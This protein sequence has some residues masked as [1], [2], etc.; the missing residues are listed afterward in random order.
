MANLSDGRPDQVSTFFI[1]I[2]LVLGIIMMPCEY[3]A[4]KLDIL[5]DG[6]GKNRYYPGCPRTDTAYMCTSQGYKWDGT[7]KEDRGIPKE[8]Y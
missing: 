4:R 3:C 6:Y 5:P 2:A 1:W 8:V 7:Y